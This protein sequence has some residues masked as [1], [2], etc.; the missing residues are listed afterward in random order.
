MQ[1]GSLSPANLSNLTQ[2]SVLRKHQKLSKQY[3]Y[4]TKIYLFNQVLFRHTQASSKDC[5]LYIAFNRTRIKD[6]NLWFMWGQNCN[7]SSLTLI[8]EAIK[9]LE[10]L[11]VNCWI[12]YCSIMDLVPSLKEKLCVCSKSKVKKNLWNFT[13]YEKKH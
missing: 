11:I 5:W 7:D 9:K 1:W 6:K 8:D 12:C 2:H 4:F 10:T 3:S 13:I